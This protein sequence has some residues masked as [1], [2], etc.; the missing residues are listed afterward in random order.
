MRTLGKGLVEIHTSQ[1]FAAEGSTS[2]VLLASAHFGF[3][4]STTHVCTGSILGSGVGKRMASV[5]WAVAGRMAGAWLVTLP[6][7]ALVGGVAFKVAEVIGGTL[8]V[9][10]MGALMAA[11]AAALYWASRRAPVNHENVNAEWSGSR[12]TPHAQ[13]AAVGV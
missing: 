11:F 13:P 5:R 1:G 3:P 10:V 2:A 6:A 12:P 4:L 7:A 8:G 9:L